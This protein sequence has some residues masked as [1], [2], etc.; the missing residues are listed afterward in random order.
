[1]GFLTIL[2]SD[3]LHHV[4]S[5]TQSPNE[6]TKEHVLKQFKDVFTGIGKLENP[7]K[8]HLNTT[9]KPVAHP[10]RKVPVAI[11]DGLKQKLDEMVADGVITPITEATDW[12]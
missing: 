4:H 10:P 2:D 11:H 1:M 8:I 12:V 6:L 5:S 7:Y 9:V 3:Q